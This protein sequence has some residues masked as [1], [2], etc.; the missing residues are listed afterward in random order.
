MTYLKYYVL[1]VKGTPNK[2]SNLWTTQLSLLLID[3]VGVSKY[4]D[5]MLGYV[6]YTFCIMS[7]YKHIQPKY[8]LVENPLDRFY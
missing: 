4:C 7:I 8:Q 6:G 2:H 5:F 3:K 1:W